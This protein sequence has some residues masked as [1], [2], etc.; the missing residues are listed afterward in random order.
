[1]SIPTERVLA[2]VAAV[3]VAAVARAAR[4]GRA[5]QAHADSPGRASAAPS[6]GRCPKQQMQRLPGDAV[7]R[8][9]LA[10]LDQAPP[11]TGAQARRHAGD[12]GHSGHAR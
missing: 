4:A 3:V 10:A 2:V 1:V 9:A 12:G 5:L 7:A 8:A 6:E 11:Y